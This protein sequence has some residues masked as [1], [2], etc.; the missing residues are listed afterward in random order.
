MISPF[1]RLV[2]RDDGDL[3]LSI[4]RWHPAWIAWCWRTASELAAVLKVP[5]TSLRFWRV[6]LDTIVRPR[7]LRVIVTPK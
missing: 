3:E 4:R 2:R 1:M 5:R 7:P 6:L